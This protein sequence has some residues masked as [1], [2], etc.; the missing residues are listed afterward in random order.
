[1]KVASRFPVGPAPPGPSGTP[2]NPFASVS[3]IGFLSRRVLLGIWGMTVGSVEVSELRTLAGTRGRGEPSAPV[4][5]GRRWRA[6]PGRD[7]ETVGG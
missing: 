3:V 6:L 2:P 5:S 1:M 7:E 4:G